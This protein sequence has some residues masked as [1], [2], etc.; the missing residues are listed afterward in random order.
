MPRLQLPE[1]PSPENLAEL[2]QHAISHVSDRHL[3]SII[4]RLVEGYPNLTPFQV[5]SALYAMAGE[6]HER[7]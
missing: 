1:W 4:A 2:A 7:N 6:N 5:K 3:L